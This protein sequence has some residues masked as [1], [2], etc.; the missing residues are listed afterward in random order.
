MNPFKVILQ[1]GLVFFVFCL[2]GCKKIESEKILAIT[3]DDIGFFAEGIYIFKG[4][5][6][7]IG[8]EK[9][10]EHGF[11]WSES[12]NPES[13]GTLIRLGPINTT[14][15]FSSMIYDISP[16]T[17]YYVKAFAITN[18]SPYYGDEKS[19]TTPDNLV[20][21]IFDIDH[22]MYYPVNIGDQ[23]WMS[24]NLKTSHYPDGSLIQRIEDPVIWFYMPWYNN[25]YCWYDNF[26]AIAASY[27]NLYTWPAAMNINSRNDIKTGKVQGVCPDGWHLPSD[28]E[29]KQLEMFLGM[30]QTEADEEKWRGEDEGGK[31]KTTE[32]FFWKSPNIGATNESSFRAL[33]AGWRDGA[34][35]FRNIESSTRFWSSSIRGDYAWMRQ[36]DYNSSL[37]FR[38][39]TGVY[40]GISVR[41]IK[42]QPEN[43]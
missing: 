18:S 30:S 33:A 39:T 27:G 41:C 25:A 1:I 29:W 36:L 10:T 12:T 14:G 13:N 20:L 38:G 7:S 9:I 4:T 40:E 8:K 23:I 16:G 28:N 37:I 6:V 26:G 15:D 11:C 42:D 22:N 43:R 24:E 35:I 21:P 2:N 3:T 34:G 5:I 32:P 17:T 31:M 19:F